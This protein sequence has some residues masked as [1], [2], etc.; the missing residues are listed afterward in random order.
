MK[1]KLFLLV[2]IFSLKISAQEK[3]GEEY[4]Y[5]ATYQLDYQE[6]ST[7]QNSMKSETVVLYLGEGVSRYSSLGKAVEDSLTAT[8]DP[9]NKS[10]AEFY[11]I[12]SL[13]PDTDFHYKIFKNYNDNEIILAEK[14]FK[15]K[16]KYKQTL[17]PVDWEIQSETKEILGYKVQKASGSFAGRNY[18][19][20]FAPE[21]PFLD[22]PYKFGGLPGLILEISDTKNHYR[23]S[24]MEFQELKKI[25]SKTLNLDDYKEV[26]QGDLD[27]VRGD[28]KRDPLTAMTNGGVTIHWKDGQEEEAKRKFQKRHKKQNNPI[29]L[30]PK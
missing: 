8:L 27:Q 15:D 22:G 5:K 14:V 28:Y 3:H 10:M 11:R 16:L 4:N 7:D 25:V 26:S 6:D 12:R 20:W 18:E 17:N 21:L 24:I 1:L 19:A 13:T 30:Q 2:I 29:E 23:F 9:S